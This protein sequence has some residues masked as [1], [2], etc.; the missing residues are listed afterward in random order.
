MKFPNLSEA[1]ASLNDDV[2]YVVL[3]NWENLP[4][5]ARSGPHGDLDLLVADRDKAVE[6][7]HATK[8]HPESWRTQYEVPIGDS[9]Q[10]TDIRYIG[11]SYYPEEMERTLLNNREFLTEKGFYVPSSAP[12]SMLFESL[13][14][15]VA[16]HKKWAIS[17]NYV[18]L[19]EEMGK[20][21][22][23]REWDSAVLHDKED[24]HAGIQAYLRALGIRF[25]KPI[26]KSV[27]F[28]IETQRWN[29][30]TAIVERG[31]ISEVAKIFSLQ[32]RDCAKREVEALTK[33]GESQHVPSLTS[34]DVGLAADEEPLI[35]MEFAG[36]PLTK[37]NMPS[38]W[39]K[40]TNE[41]GGELEAA[42]IVHRDIMPRNL[43][44]K[45]GIIML[46]DFGWCVPKGEENKDIPPDLGGKWRCKDGFNDRYSLAKS[47]E[48]ILK[49]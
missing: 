34:I 47:I 18:K 39:E 10:L 16:I 28:F 49:G 1:F 21:I 23:H 22:G 19:L 11:D 35:T 46:I 31:N 48:T 41:I 38:D 13:L 17:P 14:Y 33:L 6:A 27:G 2:P 30:V 3:R 8:C 24:Q 4:E 5:S 25:V 12:G 29:G 42:K 9:F 36:Y 15:H 26:D 32:H 45:R 37:A 20:A 44:V 7:L 40:Q 43:M